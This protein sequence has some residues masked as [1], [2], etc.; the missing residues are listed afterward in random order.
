MADRIET[1]EAPFLFSGPA[2]FGRFLGNIDWT[3]GFFS[4]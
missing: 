2:I 4:M 3:I 1:A